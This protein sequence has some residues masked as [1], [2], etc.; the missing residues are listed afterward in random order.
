MPQVPGLRSPHAKVGRIVHFGRMLDKI[1]IHARGSLPADYVASLGDIR[2]QLLDARCCRFLGVAYGDLR[3]RT[4]EGGCDEEILAWAHSRGAPRSD[5]ECIMWNSFMAKMGWRDDRSDGLRQRIAAYGIVDPGI[6]TQFEL[7]DVDE[8]RPPGAT[9]SWEP[10]PLSTVIVM[11]VSG[12]GKTTVG[13]G[14]AKAAGWEFVE[15]DSLHPPANVAKMSAGTALTDADRAPWLAA[16]RAEIEARTARGARVVAACSAL[17]ESYRAVVA[18]DTACARFVHLRGDAHVI[19]GRMA[20]RRGHYMKGSLLRSQFET[21]EEPPYA[22]T[23]DA[24]LAPDV[25]IGRIQ[26]VLGIP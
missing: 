19:S 22:L 15:G 13:E 12:S 5:E 16:V 11:G 8:G 24:A 3:P 7:L 10:Q 23:L 17:R 25:L 18:P 9:R 14:L 26:K 4:L 1:R 6:V 2:P 21:L 20:A